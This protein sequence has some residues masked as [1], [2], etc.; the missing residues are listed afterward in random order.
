MTYKCK[1]H[2]KRETQQQ[3][4]KEYILKN[5]TTEKTQNIEQNTETKEKTQRHLNYLFFQIQHFKTK[6]K[7]KQNNISKLGKM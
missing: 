1:T 4:R 5:R 6:Q 3:K 7:R 2:N